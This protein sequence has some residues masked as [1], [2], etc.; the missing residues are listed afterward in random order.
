[1][2][3]NKPPGIFCLE[4]EWYSSL[5]DTTSVRPLLEVLSQTRDLKVIHRSVNN[6]EGLERFLGQWAEKKYS[7]YRLGYFAFHGN[8]GEVAGTDWCV[9]LEEFGG[10]LSGDCSDKIVYFGACST[11]R[12]PEARIQAFLHDTGVSC[13]AGFR[14][15]IDWLESAAFEL[16][17]LAALA[18]FKF[19]SGADHWLER[20]HAAFIKR[21]GFEMYYPNKPAKEA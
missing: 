9:T 20:E 15:Q 13:V 18:R 3:K 16:M 5:A 12:I 21:T 8:R 17:L 14:K 11:L 6:R 2:A 1:M 10:M 4:G 7:A 19:P